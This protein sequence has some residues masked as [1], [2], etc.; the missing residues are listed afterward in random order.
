[1]ENRSVFWGQVIGETEAGRL[2]RGPLWEQ[3]VWV[4]I[5]EPDTLNIRKKGVDTVGEGR[6]ESK[7]SRVSVSSWVGGEQQRAQ[8]AQSVKQLQLRS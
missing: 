7:R 4:L 3:L 8:G 1:M 5:L 6:E 2:V